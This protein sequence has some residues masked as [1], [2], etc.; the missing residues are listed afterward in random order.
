MWPIKTCIF[1]FGFISSCGLSLVFPIVGII[2]YMMIYQLNPDDTWWGKPLEDLDVRMSLTAAVCM[3]LG[4]LISA[5][6]KAGELVSALRARG[7]YVDARDDILR[8]GPAPYV[9]DDDLDAAAA[10]L[11]ALTR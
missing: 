3:I 1:V 11:R 8:L 7:I 2:T 9:T 10:A 4:M 6:P 5:H